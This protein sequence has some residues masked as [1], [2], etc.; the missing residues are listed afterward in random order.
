MKKHLFLTL[1]A[2]FLLAAVLSSAGC[3]TAPSDSVGPAAETT[4]MSSQSSDEIDATPYLVLDTDPGCDDVFACFL[5]AKVVTEP[6]MYIASVGNVPRSLTAANLAVMDEYLDLKG[7]TA[8]GAE[9]TLWGLDVE[10]DGFNGIDGLGNISDKLKEA[11]G[12]NESEYQFDYQNLDEIAEEL[13]RHDN[14]T[15]LLT[16][17]GST[18]ARLPKMEPELKN[19]IRKLIVMG[20]GLEIGDTPYNTE[21][22]FNGDTAALFKLL[23]SGIQIILFPLDI[24]VPY[25]LTKEDIA[26]FKDTGAYPELTMILEYL[27]SVDTTYLSIHPDYKWISTKYLMPEGAM[28]LHDVFPLLYAQNPEMFSLTEKK[29]R[30]E[31]SLASHGRIIEHEFGFP[32]YVAEEMKDRDYIKDLILKAYTS[33]TVS[34]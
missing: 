32:I 15:Y 7:K 17:P 29:I 4:D 33:E 12:F 23:Q 20:G 9:K 28:A 6:D 18:I 2:V 14:I 5:A 24:T 10:Y 8:L 16:G 13:M 25:Y 1:A 31:A 22:N 19:H 26:E 11:C 30:A 27:G 21:Y 3:V 34:A